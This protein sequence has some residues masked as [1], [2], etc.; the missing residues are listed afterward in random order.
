MKRRNESG[1]LGVSLPSLLS[2]N[3]SS[4]SPLPHQQKKKIEIYLIYLGI[5]FYILKDFYDPC[6]TSRA[7]TE[8]CDELFSTLTWTC[9]SGY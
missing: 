5:S 2:P 1:H 7:R 9:P 8:N 4:G 3:F 6:S